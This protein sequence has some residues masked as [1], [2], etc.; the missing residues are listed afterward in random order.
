[1]QPSGSPLSQKAAGLISRP[2]GSSWRRCT[3][4]PLTDSVAPL[5]LPLL[6]VALILHK[7]LLLSKISNLPYGED[8][9]I[10]ALFPEAVAVELMKWKHPNGHPQGELSR[11]NGQNKA[12]PPPPKKSPP[13]IKLHLS[14]SSTEFAHLQMWQSVVTRFSFH[15]GD[16]VFSPSGFWFL[17][18]Q[19]GAAALFLNTSG[20]MKSSRASEADAASVCSPPLRQEV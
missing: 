6:T 5:P 18:L 4:G 15:T 3:S 1:M 8:Y 17:F 11:R 10:K 13:G 14:S 16:S 19:P 2:A 9:L 12:P 7:N 20:T